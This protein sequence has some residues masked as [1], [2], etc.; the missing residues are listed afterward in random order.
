MRLLEGHLDQEV[1]IVPTGPLLSPVRFPFLSTH[2][3][4]YGIYRSNPFC[5]AACKPACCATNQ[6]RHRD[7]F[8]KRPSPQQ[9]LAVYFSTSEGS[10][11]SC[12]L[13]SSSSMSRLSRWLSCKRVAVGWANNNCCVHG[14]GLCPRGAPGCRE[15]AQNLRRTSRG[16][17]RIES[18][19][20]LEELRY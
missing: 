2:I 18:A 8:E 1:R 9:Y 3:G 7:Q 20:G 15:L 4:K 5:R 19:S 16:L 11:L 14:F 6:I 13:A 12:H 17:I 10:G